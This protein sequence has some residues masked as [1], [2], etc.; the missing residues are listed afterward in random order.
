[1]WGRSCPVTCEGIASTLIGNLA[2]QHVAW[3]EGALAW[4]LNIAGKVPAFQPY[5][6]LTAGGTLNGKSKRRAEERDRR[7]PSAGSC[8]AIRTQCGP[9]DPNVLG[10]FTNVAILLDRFQ[11]QCH[12]GRRSSQLPFLVDVGQH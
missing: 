1:M 7:S 10:T 8:V 2:C 4:E 3:E 11:N 6:V 12:H 5:D 9:H